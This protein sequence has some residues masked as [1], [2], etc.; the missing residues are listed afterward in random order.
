VTRHPAPQ[1]ARDRSAAA[2]VELALLLP[3]LMLLFVLAIDFARIF[4]FMLTLENCARNGAY[5]AG[6]YPGIYAYA[7]MNAAVQADAP[8]LSPAPTY[9]INYATT[10]SGPYTLSTPPL[11]SRNLAT[12]FVEV[13]V[14]WDFRTISRFPGVPALTTLSRSSRMRMAPVIP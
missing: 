13:R 12:G 5:F 7:T 14:N 1:G 6:N 8:N 2:V 3:F 4:Y 10:E 11:D 9:T